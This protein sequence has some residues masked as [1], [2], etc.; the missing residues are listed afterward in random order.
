MATPPHKSAR[1]TASPTRTHEASTYA[2]WQAN[3]AFDEFYGFIGSETDQFRPTLFQDTNRVLLDDIDAD[4]ILDRDLADHAIEWLR[5]LN[6]DHPSKPFF[7]YSATGSAHAPQQAPADWIA[8]FA[9]RST[10]VVV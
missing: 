5:Q 6:A 4:Y 1:I 2:H 9:D 7:L 3:K 8:R 10:K